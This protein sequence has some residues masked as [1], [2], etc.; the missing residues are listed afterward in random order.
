MGML[1]GSREECLRIP[2]S[3][4]QARNIKAG[5]GSVPMD[6]IIFK[7]GNSGVVKSEIG[8]IWGGMTGNTIAD[9]SSG[10][11]TG[12]KAMWLLGKEDCKALQFFFTKGE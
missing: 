2:I 7:L 4:T 10:K 5:K 6:P 12:S 3:F 8:K 9:A 1:C 11:V